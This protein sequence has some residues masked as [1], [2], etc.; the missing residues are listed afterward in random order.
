MIEPILSICIVTLVKRTGMLASLLRN[1][2]EQ[3]DKYPGQVEFVVKSDSGELTTGA[4]RNLAYRE[5]TG[6]YVVSIDDDDEVSPWYV[7]EIL[8]GATA[9]PDAMAINGTMTTNGYSLATWDIS[10]LNPYGR[11]AKPGNKTHYLRYHNHIS[12]IR[13]SI[14]I[15][16]P[17]PDKTHQEDFDFATAVHKARV[18]KTEV[19]IAR[20]MYHY[21]YVSVK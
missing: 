18:I 10:R 4:K 13:R 17:F 15:Q 7:E 5:A 11:V 19:K 2:S 9:D 3:A 12:P 16:F 14:A 6:K 21:K 1:L 8:K 20:P